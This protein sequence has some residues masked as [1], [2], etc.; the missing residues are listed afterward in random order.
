[1]ARKTVDLYA[2]ILALEILAR[3]LERDCGDRFGVWQDVG[4]AAHQ[5][6]GQHVG[7]DPREPVA[8]R[9]DH[10]PLDDVAQFADVA[11]PVVR[12]KRRHRLG[13]SEEHTSELQSLMRTSYAVFC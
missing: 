11:G 9:E 8:R 6:G 5:L 4:A 10:D 2:Q 3:L 1:M 12:L 7:V 13:S